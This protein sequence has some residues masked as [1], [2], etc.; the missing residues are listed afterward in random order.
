MLQQY[1]FKNQIRIQMEEGNQQELEK[2]KQYQSKLD[3]R[4]R[5]QKLEIQR[6]EKEK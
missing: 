2:I 6:K 3:V 1:E 4:D 5:Q